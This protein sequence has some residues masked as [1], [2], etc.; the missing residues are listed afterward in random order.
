VS[1]LVARR[2]A[3][4]IDRHVEDDTGP[5]AADSLGSAPPDLPDIPNDPARLPAPRDCAGNQT[6]AER[7]AEY[8]SKVEAEYRQEAV[9][10]GCDRVREI[11][12]TVVTPA[13]LHIEAEDP[14]RRLVGFENR[15]KGRERLAEK[16]STQVAAQPGLTP[17]EALAGVKDAIRYTFQYAEDKYAVGATADSER[18]KAKGFEFVDQRNT[19]D[20]EEYKGINS[21][22]R[23]PVS[24]L[25]LE[26][27]FHTQASYEAKQLT[28][29]AYERIR[30]PGT[31]AAYLATLV[32]LADSQS[33]PASGAAVP[34]GL[35][36]TKTILYV[37]KLYL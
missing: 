18:L 7:F 30:D 10:R 31:N 11:E 14:D 36:I 34:A 23:E 20:R 2:R 29:A 21:W 17:E 35:M 22:W 3:L 6:P 19:W 26:V 32:T 28:H 13:V 27:Q 5:R 4:G 25:L 37:N 15:L 9:D 16:V 33:L 8:K 1:R 12:R 24:G